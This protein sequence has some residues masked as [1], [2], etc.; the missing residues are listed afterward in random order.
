MPEMLR[1][2]GFPC[3]DVDTQDRSGY[4]LVTDPEIAS[5]GLERVEEEV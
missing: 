1:D 5:T 3:L 4:Y 2:D